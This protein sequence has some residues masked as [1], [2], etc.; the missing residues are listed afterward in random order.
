MSTSYIPQMIEYWVLVNAGAMLLLVVLSFAC[1]KACLDGL[2]WLDH[3]MR[4]G[5]KRRADG[6][7]EETRDNPK[8]LAK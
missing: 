1:S 3:R 5:P 8:T 2:E 4:D 7:A 6:A